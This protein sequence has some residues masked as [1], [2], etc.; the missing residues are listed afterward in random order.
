VGYRA[1][2]HERKRD[3]QMGLFDKAK[4]FVEKL[5]STPNT[6]HTT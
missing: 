4:E 3:P 1:F 2:G 5:D 6:K